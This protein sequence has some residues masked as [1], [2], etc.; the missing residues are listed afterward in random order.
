VLVLDQ[1]IS[2]VPVK[3][4]RVDGLEI[5]SS[6]AKQSQ[7][8]LELRHAYAYFCGLGLSKVPIDDSWRRCIH[9]T[10]V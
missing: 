6:L 3:T 2:Y 9:K 4:E 8:P 10:F 7:C 5:V 1:E